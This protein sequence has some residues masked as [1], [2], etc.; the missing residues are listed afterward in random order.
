M[1]LPRW[2]FWVWPVSGIVVVIGIY[3]FLSLP[4]FVTSGPRYCLTCHATGD[5]ANVGQASLVH[6]GYNKVS[7]TACHAKNPN[8]PVYVEGYRGGYSAD[9]KQVSTRCQSCHQDVLD[10]Q[11][12]EFKF[13]VMEINIPHR[14]HVETVGAKCTDCH[15][16]VAHDLSAVPTN[17]PRMEYCAQCHSIAKP[18]TGSSDKSSCLKCHVK[19]VPSTD[20]FVA[21]PQAEPLKPA[22]QQQGGASV[23]QPSG[24]PNIPHPLEGRDQCL[25]CHGQGGLKPVPADHAG[26][27]EQMCRLCHQPASQ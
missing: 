5:T 13:N 27:T 12:S 3:G 26:R 2:P 11:P 25:L 20:F 22:P 16:N 18:A 10:K 7:C 8:Q 4:R 1:K 23:Q 15:R 14:F 19:G 24:P 21:A 9:P 17:R 6:P